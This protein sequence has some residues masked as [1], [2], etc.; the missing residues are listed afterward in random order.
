MNKLQN[1]SLK[2]VLF[3]S[4]LAPKLVYMKLRIFRD[5]EDCILQKLSDADAIQ[6]AYLHPLDVRFVHANYRKG[7][8]R[9][10]CLRWRVNECALEAL[11]TAFAISCN[12]LTTTNKR[13]CIAVDISGE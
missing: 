8:S 9:N 10:G 12:N 6:K 1:Y 13:Y 7:R 11:E 3:I 2:Y 5:S 4:S